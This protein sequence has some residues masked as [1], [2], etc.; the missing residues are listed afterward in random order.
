MNG[1]DRQKDFEA[2]AKSAAAFAAIFTLLAGAGAGFA[3]VLPRSIGVILA[4]V[5]LAALIAAWRFSVEAR[6]AGVAIAAAEE[7]RKRSELLRRAPVAAVDE[8][9]PT[10]IGVD[11]AAQD[12]LPGGEVPEYVPRDADGELREALEAALDGSGRWLVVVIGPSK[13]GKSRT[14]FEAVAMCAR[15]RALELVA[16]SDADAL[17][18][19][20]AS[21][22]EPKQRPAPTVLWLDDLETFLNDGVT[23]ATLREWRSGARGGIVVGTYGG[24]GSERIAGSAS[25]GLATI[26]AEVLQ[27]ARR[28]PVGG[29]HDR[30][31]L[32][33][34]APRSPL[35]SLRRLSVMVWRR[36]WWRA[37]AL[38]TSSLLTARAG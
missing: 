4:C 10:Q 21:V 25:G 23:M 37:Q 18:A 28:D 2:R 22:D 9:E 16:P 3:G 30:A 11:A 29:D 32:R 13:V 8:I 12:I 20:L 27:S 5:A 26:A 31:S 1:A 35:S 14:L 6:D 36:T 38:E 17:R 24:K 34:C 7:E 15:S 19:S 33:R